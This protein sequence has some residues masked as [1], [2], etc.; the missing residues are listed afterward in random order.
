MLA[1][2]PKMRF[3][4]GITSVVRTIVAAALLVA[5]LPAAARAQQAQGLGNLSCGQFINAARSSDIL[6]H[7]ASSWLL[8]YASGRNEALKDTGATVPAAGM[9]NDQLLNLAG[10]YYETNP[11]RTIVEAANQ[12]YASAPRP[13]GQTGQAPRGWYIDLNKSSGY[14]GPKP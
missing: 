4:V 10:D 7:Q 8:G 6:Y 5:L 14:R 11:S 1:S 3:T 13:V 9:S 2:R 12:W